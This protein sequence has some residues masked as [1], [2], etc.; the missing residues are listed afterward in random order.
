[1]KF[2][3]DSIYYEKAR[4]TKQ[5]ECLKLN[6]KSDTATVEA[7]LYKPVK[8]TKKLPIIIYNRGGMG[9][10]GNLVE[11][12]L[13]DFHKMAENGYIVIATKT[14][15]AGNNGK[16]DQH[17]GVDV[18]DIVNLKTVYEKLSYVD[19]SN[20]FMYGF[21]RGGQK[22]VSSITQNEIKCNGGYSFCYRLAEKFDE[23]KD[24]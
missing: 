14:R 12:N 15:F 11:T 18:D 21:S 7:W 10:F 9:N 23:Q 19:T 16:Y 4:L 2:Y 1:M 13:V 20:V 17:G 8:T 3:Y 22:Y 6:Y 5:F 24:L